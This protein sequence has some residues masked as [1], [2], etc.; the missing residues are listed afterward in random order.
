MLTRPSF[1]SA[2]LPS[3]PLASM[4]M[5]ATRCV[6]AAHHVLSGASSFAPWLASA[7]ELRSAG[8]VGALYPCGRPS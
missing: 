4:S 7:D 5:E 2:S 8:F 1:I 6:A 3:A